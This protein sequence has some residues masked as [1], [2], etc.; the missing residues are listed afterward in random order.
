[1]IRDVA[2]TIRKHSGQDLAGWL[3]PA[4][5]NTENTIELL[6]EAGVNTRST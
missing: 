5:A 2:D 3:S 4:L 6:A 1:M